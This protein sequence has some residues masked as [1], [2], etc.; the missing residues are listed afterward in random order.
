MRAGAH[1]RLTAIG[2]LVYVGHTA[3]G[4]VSQQSQQGPLSR[5]EAA[6]AIQDSLT[7]ALA[8]GVVATLASTLPDLDT[9]FSPLYRLAGPWRRQ[10]GSRLER[11]VGHR[12]PLHSG[13]VAPLMGGLVALLVA[14][15]SLLY[16]AATGGPLAPTPWAEW[17]IYPVTAGYL[18]HIAEDMW[19]PSGVPLLWPIPGLRDLLFRW[20]PWPLVIR[21][22]VWLPGD[23]APPA[24]WWKA[25]EESSF[26][27]V[28]ARPRPW[29]QPARSPGGS[30]GVRYRAALSGPSSPPPRVELTP[31]GIR[32][33]PPPG[34]S[35]AR[36]STG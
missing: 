3:Y 20:R 30:S 36:R 33:I 21:G 7:H 27:R 35:P 6:A 14:I 31:E 23:A 17:L 2:A 12:G 19:T 32:L 1:M 8:V 26:Q 18:A 16:A 29:G 24:P 9:R 15:G 34:Q 5:P 13:L 28:A 11:N 10:I 22:A 25:G 4:V